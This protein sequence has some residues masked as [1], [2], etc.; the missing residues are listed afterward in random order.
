MARFFSCAGLDWSAV[1]Q[2]VFH[3]TNVFA[4][5]VFPVFDSAILEISNFCFRR[6]CACASAPCSARAGR[7]QRLRPPLVTTPLTPPL[8][9]STPVS[10]G[11][12][13]NSSNA[14][15]ASILPLFA[16]SARLILF[17]ACFVCFQR[18]LVGRRRGGIHD[19][20]VMGV[21]MPRACPAAGPRLP[22][23]PEPDRACAGTEGGSDR[24]RVAPGPRVTRRPAARLG[25]SPYPLPPA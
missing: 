13:P 19:G 24:S 25:H 22:S 3:S 21:L 10:R 18:A 4:D 23:V 2:V 16:A 6:F 9:V 5:F 12:W 11:Q 17:F 20:S 15:A 7:S 8:T 14:S 1:P